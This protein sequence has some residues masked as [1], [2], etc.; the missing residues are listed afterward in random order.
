MDGY[1][2]ATGTFDVVDGPVTV[3]VNMVGING[4]ATANLKL[5]P[6]P[7]KGTFHIEVNGTYN[8]TVMNAIGRTIHTEKVNGQATIDMNNASEVIYFIKLQDGNKVET[9]RFIISR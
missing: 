2:D 3:P 6:N 5:Y 9:Q 1:P 8:I 7:N 4:I